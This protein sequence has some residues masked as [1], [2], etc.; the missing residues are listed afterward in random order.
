[1]EQIAVTAEISIVITSQSVSNAVGDCKMVRR[2]VH[3][4]S[5]QSINGI[6]KVEHIGGTV[7]RTGFVEYFADKSVA[8]FIP[9]GFGKKLCL[10][11]HKQKLLVTPV[12]ATSIVNKLVNEI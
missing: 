11:N 7:V 5:V 2:T 1:M 9:S 8:F 10:F 4:S 6:L 3:I 12:A